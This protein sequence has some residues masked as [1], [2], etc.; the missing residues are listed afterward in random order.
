[1]E[2]L[3]LTADIIAVAVVVVFAVLGWKKGMFKTMSGFMSVLVGIFVAKVVADYGATLIADYL[4]PVFLPVVEE[5]LGAILAESALSGEEATLGILGLIPGVQEVVENAAGILAQSLA[6]AIALEVA[7][8]VAWVVLFVVGFLASKLLVMLVMAILNL[9]DNIPG[10]HF[11]N[12]AVGLILGALKGFLL[13][14]LIVWVA[15]WFNWLPQQLVE[16]SYVV[17]WLVD[18]LTV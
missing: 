18:V 9:I 7:S 4:V 5:K 6:P 8:A 16:D 10:L 15:T 17:S 3:N 1:M 14:L 11:L 12:H 2:I 13:V